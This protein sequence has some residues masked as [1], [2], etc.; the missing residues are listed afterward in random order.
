MKFD[1]ITTLI[2]VCT[3]A[4]IALTY[5]IRIAVRG[6]AHYDRIDKQGGSALLSK[7]V[8]EGAYWSMQ[9]V[10]KL[11]VFFRVTPNMVSWASLATGFLA[12]ACLAVGH[13]GFGAVFSI[14]SALLDALDGMVARITGVSSDSGEVLDA[15]VDRYVEFFFIGGLLIYYRHFPSLLILALAALIGSFMIS[16]S[17]A[18]AEALGVSPPKGSMRRP[19]RAAYLSIGAALSPFTIPV[20]EAVRD[21]PV[22]IGHPMVMALCLVAL[23]ANFSAAERFLAIAREMRKREF[24]KLL[25]KTA[26]AETQDE[27]ASENVRIASREHTR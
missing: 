17:T 16:Y 15:A 14:T 5:I 11:L 26:D 9:P 22:A 8:M 7:G 3:V 27:C 20:F 4:L 23:V 13:F 21:Y 12:G 2:L 10:A 6:R 19:E 1:F 24:E 25:A 18:K